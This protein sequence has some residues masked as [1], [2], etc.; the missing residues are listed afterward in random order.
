MNQRA[1]PEQ[2]NSFYLFFFWECGSLHI[3]VAGRYTRRDKNPPNMETELGKW[4][5]GERF[6][7]QNR[8]DGWGGMVNG[9]HCSSAPDAGGS[10]ACC[11]VI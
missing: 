4:G 2:T 3:G 7:S 10:L 5:K 1:Q 9:C 6:K 11:G 8:T